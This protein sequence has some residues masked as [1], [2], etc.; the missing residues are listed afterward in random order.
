VADW[1]LALGGSDHDFSA[2]L[3][4]DT[5]IRVA[6]EQERLSRRKY[7]ACHWYED[8]VRLAIEYCLETEGISLADVKLVVSND[9][10]PNRVCREF[11]NR[12]RLY[13]H[14][15]CHAAS[16]YLLVPP[17]KKAGV[18]VYDG[19]GSVAGEASTEVVRNWRETFSF[20]NFDVDGFQLLGRTCGL[21]FV[22]K[23]DF[24]TGV[25]N[26]IGMLTE[27]ITG[28]LG[29][30]PDDAGKTMGLASYGLPRYTAAL[31][32][33]IEFGPTLADC[34]R[35][36]TDNSAL[37]ET[38]DRI[39][40]EGRGAFSTRADV[41][42]SLQAVI[43]KTLVHCYRLMPKAMEYLCLSGGCALNTV[44]TTHLI[45]SEDISIPV[46]A[47][48]HCG[49]S[50]LAF[51]ALWLHQFEQTNSVPSL[52][53][54]GC[55][56]TPS[57]ARPGREYSV[58]ACRSAAN[59]F[60]PRLV[61]D[62]SV[63]SAEDVARI[64]AQGAI[65]GLFNGASEI[66]PRALGGR[67][68]IADPKVVAVRETINRK[69]KGREPFRPLAPIVLASDYERYF[70]DSR[71]ADEYMLKV[72]P[73]SL[74]CRTDAPA[75]VHTDGT[76]RTQVIGTNGDRFLASLLEAFKSET[77]RGVLINTSF[78]RRGEPLV[79]TPADA[80]DAFLGMGLDGL[81][82]NGLYFRSDNEKADFT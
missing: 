46:V 34:F 56:P 43:N 4:R 14:H 36:A 22:E 74:L 11:S 10:L 1:I 73:A 66:G 41:A 13:P 5:D 48:P 20:Y 37:I 50:G 17:G 47:P 38:V 16:A 72:V 61:P 12:L 30:S 44:A 69:L 81:Y 27:M 49:D 70:T 32:Q 59:T 77:G 42:A 52:T 57:L 55:Q 3:M 60:Y 51:G 35:C 62:A 71:L 82:M 29:F 76:A 28:L 75:V 23:D 54:R 78:N 6:I 64:V 26:S 15:L 39:L 25:T 2:A 9:M 24:P 18:I 40:F 31:E 79:E 19:Y 68:I 58:E 67:S 65:V 63:H 45:T 80:I 33:F 7:G 53:F 21:G 8:P